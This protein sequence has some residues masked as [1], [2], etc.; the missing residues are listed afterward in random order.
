MQREG[1]R[2]SDAYKAYVRSNGE[3]AGWVASVMAQEGTGGR[4]QPWQGTKWGRVVGSP[5][6]GKKR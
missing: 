2:A 5:G 4:I 1:Q 6:L 3:D